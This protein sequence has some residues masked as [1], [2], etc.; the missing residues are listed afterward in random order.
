MQDVAL[1]LGPLQKISLG[2]PSH[3]SWA[4]QWQLSVDSVEKSL[5]G[6][7]SGE[8]LMR[9]T[10]CVLRTQLERVETV[11]DSFTF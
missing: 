11:P 8:D 5:N 10:R 9:E 2:K 3:E 6:K 7:Y 1:I 4:P